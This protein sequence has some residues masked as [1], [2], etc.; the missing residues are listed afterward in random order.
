VIVDDRWLG[1]R[2]F[3]LGDAPPPAANANGHAAAAGDGTAVTAEQVLRDLTKHLQANLTMSQLTGMQA[4]LE[5]ARTNR[6]LAPQK[7]LLET[8][9]ALITKAGAPVPSND[10]IVD[11]LMQ[12]LQ[13][14][15]A[16]LRD[17]R[18]AAMNAG[19]PATTSGVTEIAENFKALAG[20]AELIGF[21]R[22]PAGRDRSG[23]FW[24][25]DTV[26][27]IVDSAA[28]V[29]GRGLDLVQRVIESKL[30]GA[31]VPALSAPGG[32]TVA[33]E[34]GK[35]ELPPEFR[36]NVDFLLQALRS[37]D[38]KTVAWMLEN[39]FVNPLTG[40]PVVPID[41]DV[42]PL[43]YVFKIRPFAPQINDLRAELVDFL[44]WVKAPRAAAEAAPPAEAK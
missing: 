40:E 6:E 39:V 2:T 9:T 18:T 42:N 35:I 22:A 31:A 34:P 20:A 7:L 38:F 1:W 37:R 8:I 21:S 28:P 4:D 25:P 17:M 11:L 41:P 24:T 12:Q 5:A 13:T 30:A 43:A 3:A 26:K 23:S 19:K 16:E 36:E 29:L 27:G 32:P 33:K 10:R 44:A 14:L 15:Q